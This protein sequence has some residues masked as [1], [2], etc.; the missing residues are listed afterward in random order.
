MDTEVLRF[1]EG[2]ELDKADRALAQAA[3]QYHCAK[4]P[5]AKK[6]MRQHLR[7]CAVL[8]TAAAQDAAQA[9]S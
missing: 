4:T 2:S 8:F 5:E 1:E 6:A 3:H 9:Q 7:R